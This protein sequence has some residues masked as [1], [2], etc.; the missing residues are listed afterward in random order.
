[1]FKIYYDPE[2]DK[3][4]YGGLIDAGKRGE[5]IA[6]IADGNVD[7]YN[8]K[9][10]TFF[11]KGVPFTE[12]VDKNNNTFLN[13]EDCVDYLNVEL[14]LPPNSGGTRNPNGTVIPN[15]TSVTGI[16][17]TDSNGQFAM[18][19]SA[20][21]FTEIIE[22]T[23]VVADQVFD[24]LTDVTDLLQ[25]VITS[26]DPTN[27]EGV[28]IQGTSSSVGALGQTVDS[29]NRGGAGRQVRMMVRC[30]G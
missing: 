3:V 29:V 25:A 7:V 19:L 27:V 28:I 1:M 9:L 26:L 12:F 22:A 11:L 2:I 17:T 23:A 21:N 24:A 4:F 16:V 5:M 30:R 20:F 13:I 6:S 8:N 15:T 10:E 18:D 14:S